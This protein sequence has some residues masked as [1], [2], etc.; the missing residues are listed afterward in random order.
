[1]QVSFAVVR[2]TFTT[3]QTSRSSGPWKDFN[4]VLSRLIETNRIIMQ[5]TYQD[6]E[7]T[8]AIVEYKEEINRR[9]R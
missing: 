4:K 7:P 1:M 2:S 8:V 6:I 9:K 5:T 3:E